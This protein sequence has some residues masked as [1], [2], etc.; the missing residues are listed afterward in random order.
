M[1]RPELFRG[2][3]TGPGVQRKAPQAVIRRAGG[4]GRR[5][6]LKRSRQRTSRGRRFD[7]ALLKSLETPGFLECRVIGFKHMP[8]ARCR[9]EQ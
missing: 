6:N 1:N 3:A 2:L 7:N 8:Q 4:R 9:A 5:N